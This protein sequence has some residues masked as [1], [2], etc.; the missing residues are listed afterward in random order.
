MATKVLVICLLCLLRATEVI[1]HRS[2][3]DYPHLAT[4]VI[5]VI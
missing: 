5:K 4:L 3:N 2:Q 1:H